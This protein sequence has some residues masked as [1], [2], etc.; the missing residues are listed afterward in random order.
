MNLSDTLITLTQAQET[1]LFPFPFNTHLIFCCIASVFLIF[2]FIREKKPYQLIMTGA[3]LLSLT[4]WLSDNRNIFYA[5]GIAEAVLLLIA[6]VTAIIF[7]EKKT[8]KAEAQAEKAVTD[9]ADENTASD[10]NAESDAEGSSDS[11][12]LPEEN[13]SSE[14]EKA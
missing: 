14:E 13:G 10:E 2:Q 9:E 7:K 3:I 5:I 1:S 4:I 8:E 11:E 12:E 6:F